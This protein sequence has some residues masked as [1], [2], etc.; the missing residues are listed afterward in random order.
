[1]EDDIDEEERNE[2]EEFIGTWQDEATGMKTFEFSKNNQ[3]LVDL[4]ENAEPYDYFRL[5][6]DN[7]ILDRIIQETN[8]YALNLFL[9]KGGSVRARISEW[10]DLTQEEFLKF[11]GL[12]Y[13]MGTIKLNRIQDYWKTHRLFNLKCFSERMSRDRFLCILRCFHFSKNPKENEPKPDDCL[14]KIRPVIDYF[15]QKMRQIYYPGKNLSLD[16]SLVLWRGRLIFR[17]YIANKR[18]KYGLKLYML[19]EPNGLVFNFSVYT[20]QLDDMGGKGHAQKVVMGLMKDNLNVGHSVYMDNFYNSCELAQT[21]LDNKTFCTGTLR[22]NRKGNPQ[23]VIGSKLKTGE[24]KAKYF[25]G[26]LV[27][28]WRQ[29]R[30]YLH[31]YRIQQRYG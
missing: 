16:E 4:P 27:G 3:M 10:K 30:S 25:N 22:G 5:L 18:H 12:V 2:I 23:E 28:K 7:D 26:I 20:G 24:T 13:H 1:M 31:I 29:T 11:L 17:Q 8:D 14:Y 15:N 6:V 21:L 9:E 19:T